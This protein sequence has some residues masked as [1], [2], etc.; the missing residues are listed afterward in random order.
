ML[1]GRGSGGRILTWLTGTPRSRSTRSCRGFW[2]SP[3]RSMSPLM[4]LCGPVCGM[5]RTTADTSTTAWPVRTIGMTSSKN[6]SFTISSSDRPLVDGDEDAVADLA[7]DGLR[8]VALAAD[9]L[10][11]E[12]LAGADDAALA[13]A[14]R[15]LHAGVEID[16]VLAP[17][18]GVPVQVI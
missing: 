2:Y 9:V 13:V 18:R 1:D 3:K 5:P 6:T 10:H 17:G 12:H 15:D 8:E 16:D 14:G 7:V 4:R 11:Q